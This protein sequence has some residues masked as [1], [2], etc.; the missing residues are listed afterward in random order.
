MKRIII[1]FIL[2]LLVPLTYA[3]ASCDYNEIA[4]LKKI[5]SNVNVDYDYVEKNNSVTF[6]VRLTNLNNKIYFV[7]NTNYKKYL[8]TKDEIVISNYSDSQT[9]K[10]VFYPSD[11]SCGN[12]P[13]YTINLTLP[14]YNKFYTDSICKGIESYSLCQKWS[15]HNLNYDKFIEKVQDYKNSIIIESPP[16]EIEEVTE[17]FGNMIISFLI[18][19]YYLF[20]IVFIII[21][22]LIYAIRKK[23]NIYS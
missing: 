18:N 19:Y 16:E 11:S 14:T 20:I 7:D 17:T 8:Y 6:T 4:K 12:Q 13:L 3:K 9:I 23:D 5:A 15:T 22:A 10:Y 21:F 1:V 2:M